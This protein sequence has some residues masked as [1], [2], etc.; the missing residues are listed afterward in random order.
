MNDFRDNFYKA[1]RPDVEFFGIRVTTQPL[2]LVSAGVDL[3]RQVFRWRDSAF[4]E[5]AKLDADGVYKVRHCA[6]DNPAY[7]SYYDLRS[8]EHRTASS[9]TAT[10]TD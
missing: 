5:R 7:L 3:T 1:Y 6:D 4:Q 9:R 10:A 2:P 8:P